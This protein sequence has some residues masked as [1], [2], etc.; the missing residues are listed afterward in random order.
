[1]HWFW[2]GNM[3]SPWRRQ[4]SPYCQG[5]DE[6]LAKGGKEYDYDAFRSCSGTLQ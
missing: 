5:N 2:I 3:I 4:M 1:M 6:M